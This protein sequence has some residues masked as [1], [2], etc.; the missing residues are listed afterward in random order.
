LFYP[1]TQEV[2]QK[3]AN[4]LAERRKTFAAQANA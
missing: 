1:I 4:E 2:N 3:I